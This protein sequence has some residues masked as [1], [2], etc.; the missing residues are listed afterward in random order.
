MIKI[1]NEIL[2]KELY[3]ISDMDLLNIQAQFRKN[4]NFL[5]N[6]YIK[7][8]NSNTRK[9]L[10]DITFSSNYCK[11]YH[12]EL[13]NRIEV[14]NAFS[15][16]KHFIPVFITAT[17]DSQYRDFIYA[18]YRR[19]KESDLKIIPNHIKEKILNKEALTIVDL[20]D[21]F[22]YKLRIFNNFYT[23]KYKNYKITFVKVYEPHKNLGIPHLHMLI[24]IP[25][26]EEIINDFKKEYCKLFPAPQN[27]KTDRLTKEQIKNGELNGFQTSIKDCIAYIMKYLQKTFLNLKHNDINNIT[28]DKLTAWYIKYKIRRFTMS[29]FLCPLWLYRKINFIVSLRDYYF[30]NENLSLNT[31]IFEKDFKNKTFF[32]HIERTNETLIYEKNHLI[33]ETCNRIMH[34]YNAV[35]EMNKV[36]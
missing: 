18:D 17:L 20:K 11:N 5:Q 35:F 29:R 21:I 14:L 32:I 26:S 2:A 34:E 7:N 27:L 1:K 30:L 19:L 24:F 25:N 36:A 4:L 12:N 13:L 3:S 22:N 8:K 28:I 10:I 15:I 31:S 33:Y 9:T 6:H 16:E 23:R